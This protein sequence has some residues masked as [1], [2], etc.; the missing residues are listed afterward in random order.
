MEL[1]RL[2]PILERIN[3][4][5]FAS[6]D[7]RTREASVI[8]ETVGERVMLFHTRGAS[9]YENKVKRELERLGLD[10][11]QFKVG[12]LPWG[13]RV[14]NLPLITHR[15]FHYLQTIFLKPGESRYFIGTM[16]VPRP[17]FLSE[18]FAPGQG[19]PEG[20]QVIVNT[21]NIEN[22]SKLRLMK[23]VIE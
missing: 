2:I 9:G 11:N 3:G 21:Y 12:D 22:I 17:K 5:T 23:E 19:L 14:G 13:E 6:L 4:C 10:P 16:E 15:G 7:A 1:S 18:R 8:R 20:R